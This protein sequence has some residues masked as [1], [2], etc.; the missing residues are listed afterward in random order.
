LYWLL[1]CYHS[2][3]NIPQKAPRQYLLYE[4]KG[5]PQISEC[6]NVDWVGSLRENIIYKKSKEQNV[7]AQSTTKVIYK[8]M[9]CF[10]SEL[11]WV[12]WFV[13]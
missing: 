7:I 3:P 1:E 6:C 4:D 8:V 9:I 11:V 5:N 12:K 10:Y 13:Q 2:Y